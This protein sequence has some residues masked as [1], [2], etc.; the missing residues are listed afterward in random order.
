MQVTPHQEP[1]LVLTRFIVKS[2]GK[3][4]RSAQVTLAQESQK[5][6]VQ[7]VCTQRVGGRQVATVS[8]LTRSL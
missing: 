1:V 5:P 8:R 2:G 4:P 7:A 6:G 3:E